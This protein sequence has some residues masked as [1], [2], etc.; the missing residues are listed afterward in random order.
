MK[1]VNL[2]AN[3]NRFGFLQKGSIL[4]GEAVVIIMTMIVR[5]RLVSLTC[6]AMRGVASS[7]PSLSH[8]LTHRMVKFHPHGQCGFRFFIRFPTDLPMCWYKKC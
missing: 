2:S 3:A 8:K 6:S 5:S 4:V 1:R 7:L